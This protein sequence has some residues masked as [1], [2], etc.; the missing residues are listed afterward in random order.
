MVYRDFK[1]LKISALGFGAMR[2]PVVG[3]D[4][5]KIDAA[6]AKKMVEAA[7]E[8]GVNYFDTAWGYHNQQSELFLGEALKPFARESFFLSTKF[9]GYDNA[10]FGKAE[11]IFAKQLE[12]CQTG[13]FDFYLCHNVNERNIDLY[14]DDEKWRTLSFLKKMRDE[15]KI[16]HLGFSCHGELDV[17]RRFLDAYGDSMEFC[18][19]Q[20]NWIDWHF[21]NGEKKAALLK[22]RGIPLWVMEPLR[23]GKLAALSAEN[24]AA[25]KA[26]RPDASAVEWAF[27]F[28]QSIPEAVVTLSGVSTRA[29]LDENIAIF[30]K[31]APLNEKERTA[32]LAMGDAMVGSVALPCTECRYCAPRCPKGL[33]IPRILSLYNEH[34]FTE[35][36]L[37]APIGL[38]A[39]PPEK[40]P[41]ACIACGACREVCPQGI[42]IPAAMKDFAANVN[43]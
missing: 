22:E 41:S 40:R 30:A 3:G 8:G 23:G 7:I 16:R 24:E 12:K 29:Q 10:N 4:E 19:L 21:Q 14:L 18:Q 36:G 33:D 32:L 38:S 2:L 11:T 28:I 6:P 15:G 17:M 25:L 9:P 43:V 31:D 39:L 42:D 37:L 27:R 1:G 35:G 13:Y 34:A 20:I 26:M 5:G